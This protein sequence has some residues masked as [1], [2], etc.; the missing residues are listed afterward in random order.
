MPPG[1][2]RTH[3]PAIPAG[4]CGSAGV[5]SA[6]SARAEPAPIRVVAAPPCNVSLVTRAMIEHKGLACEQ[7]AAPPDVWGRLLHAL[8]V[9]PIRAPLVFVA[10]RRISGVRWVARALDELVADQP[11]FP[12]RA[13]E[14]RRVHAAC[15]W[16]EQ[17]HDA[18]RR[19][20]YCSARHDPSVFT[21]VMG[22]GRSPAARVAVGLAA[23][24]VVRFCA[25]A[26]EATVWS[27][28]EDLERLP[29][30]LAQIDEW[31][32]QG[33]LN[34]ARLNAADFQIAPS[35][36]TLLHS[37][38][39]WPYVEGR[40]AALLADRLLPQAHEPHVRLASPDRVAPPDIP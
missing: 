33:V 15:R 3:R 8:G 27:A 23:P 5:G 29:H 30:D 22:A 1:G 10:D 32:D 13:W 25:A 34:G 39:L 9:E 11:L 19:L 36:A 24:S 37:A 18:T 31:I 14:R 12:A 21:A 38:D 4:R 6:L 7:L 26:R 17:F 16:G 20:F 2:E 28:R 35:V 40:P